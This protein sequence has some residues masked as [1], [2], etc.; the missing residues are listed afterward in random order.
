VF[1][2]KSQGLTDYFA[3]RGEA[4][5]FNFAGDELVEFGGEGNI[6]RENS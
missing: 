1:F 3:G 4:A 5:G 6:Y 2:E